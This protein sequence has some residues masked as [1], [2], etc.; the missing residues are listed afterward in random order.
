MEGT[1]A[2]LF[3]ISRWGA[4]S[5]SENSDQGFGALFKAQKDGT[6]YTVLHDFGDG[7][8]GRLDGRRAARK[9]LPDGLRLI[10]LIERTS[11]YEGL[12]SWWQ[13]RAQFRLLHRLSWN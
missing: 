2:V 8:D 11:A 1:G 3:G 7:E 13:C 9:Q 5:S 10:R 6:D 4:A 12:G